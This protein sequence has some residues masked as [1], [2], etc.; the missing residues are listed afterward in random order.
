MNYSAFTHYYECF[1]QV[2]YYQNYF[3]KYIL[4]VVTVTIFI[5]I[6]VHVIIVNNTIN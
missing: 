6:F 2:C 5:A 3:V 4:T 1:Q